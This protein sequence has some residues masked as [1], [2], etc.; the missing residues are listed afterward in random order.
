MSSSAR[1]TM[2]A[3][4]SSVGRFVHRHRDKLLAAG[5]AMPG[6]ALLSAKVETLGILPNGVSGALGPVLAATVAGAI[7][8]WPRLRLEVLIVARLVG[9][10]AKS[11]LA[12]IGGAV[13]AA[14]LFWEQLGPEPAWTLAETVAHLRATAPTIFSLLL[15]LWLMGLALHLALFGSRSE[16]I[17]RAAWFDRKLVARH[18]AAHALVASVLGLP[19]EGAWVLD[20]PDRRG[21]GGAVRMATSPALSTTEAMHDLVVRRVAVNIAGVVGE[22]HGRS[23]GEIVRRLETQQDWAAA[24][25][26]SWIVDAAYPDRGLLRNLLEAVAPT[27]QT[28]PWQSAIAEAAKVLLR[29]VGDPVAPEA[30]AAIARRFGL[31]L[32][33][34]EALADAALRVARPATQEMAG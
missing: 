23:M 6:T 17:R 18:E 30:F 9:S 2:T 13:V 26:M 21:V 5:V 12:V 11:M 27:L 24:G 28:A 16:A 19:M 32:P 3:W 20:R 14:V 33:A 8:A 1:E 7:T 15:L 31:A 22:R 29:A 4:G 10:A 34:V 25:A